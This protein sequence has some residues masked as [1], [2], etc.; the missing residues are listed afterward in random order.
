MPHP[1]NRKPGE[2]RVRIE[3]QN[4]LD[5]AN[6]ETAYREIYITNCEPPAR[7][8]NHSPCVGIHHMGLPKSR[9]K[10]LKHELRNCNSQASTCDPRTISNCKPRTEELQTTKYKLQVSAL[11]LSR[12]RKLRT[13]SRDAA[14]REP[15]TANRKVRTASRVTG[16]PRIAH[17][18]CQFVSNGIC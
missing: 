9:V 4:V 14:N 11:A 13:A 3:L 1:A 17:P 16:Q 10:F 7:T 8:A 12:G 15:R 2:S 5:K 18:S 6:R